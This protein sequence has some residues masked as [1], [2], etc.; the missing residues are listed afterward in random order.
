LARYYIWFIV[1]VSGVAGLP[2]VLL[3]RRFAEL[4]LARLQQKTKTTT[5]RTMSIVF[6][7][8]ALLLA[9]A[10][11]TVWG[12]QIWLVIGVIFSLLSAAENF[13]ESL[14][15]TLDNMVFQKRLMGILYLGLS[16]GSLVVVSR[17]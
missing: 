5:A 8:G 15:P 16:A 14:V 3:A 9:A 1:V 11:F 10:Y 7:F 4:Q 17:L 12:H 6:L 2:R 13:L